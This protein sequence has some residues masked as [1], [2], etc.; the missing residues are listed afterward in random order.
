MNAI[1]TN[2]GSTS[3][4]VTKNWIN[5]ANE[6]N[7]RL[8]IIGRIYSFNTR[9]GSMDGNLK[10]L[11]TT[12]GKYFDQIQLKTDAT[13]ENAASM[14]LERFRIISSYGSQ[15]CSLS[16]NYR[17]FTNTSLPPLLQRPAGYSGG[18]C[19]F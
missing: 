13:P 18:N 9:G 19:S 6:L 4:T 16:L 10:A 1:T 14:D 7:N 17:I 15:T 2:T 11:T 12:F 3:K 5:H 8:T